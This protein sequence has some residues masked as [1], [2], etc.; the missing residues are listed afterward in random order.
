MKQRG[1]KRTHHQFFV[2]LGHGRA[3]FLDDQYHKTYKGGDT[4]EGFARGEFQLLKAT[5]CQY[6]EEE[7]QH[8]AVTIVEPVGFLEAVPNEV[9]GTGGK[10]ANKEQ[11]EQGCG[12]LLSV[13]DLL[14]EEESRN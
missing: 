1:G 12:N 3:K 2:A 9:K 6:N 5:E 4:Q 14:G 7:A 13:G 8:E 10:R 11:N